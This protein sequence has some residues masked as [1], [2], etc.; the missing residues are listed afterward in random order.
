M[1][2][3][4]GITTVEGI[5]APVWR[6][7][8]TSLLQWKI[9]NGKSASTE[10]KK[11]RF[12]Y[13]RAFVEHLA[14]M[15]LIPTPKNLHGKLRFKGGAAKIETLT[16]EEVKLL[17][18]EAPGRLKLALLLMANCGM[19][20]KDVSDMKQDEV[21]WENGRITRKRSKTENH[22]SV[23][24]VSWKLWDLTFSLLKK[25][26]ATEGE[27]AFLTKLGKTWIRDSLDSDGNR[28]RTDAIVCNWRKLAERLKIGKSLYT[29]RATGASL[30]KSKVEYA[31]Y[32][33]E[34]LG[35][36]PTSV[37][38]RH[39]AATSSEVFDQVVAWLGDQYGF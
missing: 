19:S 9:A 20:Q 12:R 21:N 4:A 34:F 22:E 14:E 13:S 2:A 32:V 5:T 31:P 28:H 30:L 3:S 27:L 26:R 8:Y 33:G 7:W 11:K 16:I 39:Y 36:S 10:S 17:V 38:D 25:Y 15:D 1:A 35:H 6:D 37:A 23:P 29:F 18:K 24:T